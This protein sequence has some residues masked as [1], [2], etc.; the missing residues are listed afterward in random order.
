MSEEIVWDGRT[1]PYIPP[2]ELRIAPGLTLHD[3]AD[4]TIDPVT[5]EVLRHALWNVNT[6]H[7]NTIMKISGSPICAYGHDFNPWHVLQQ[8]P[9]TCPYKR[10]IISQQYS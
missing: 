1:Y 9:N 6:E 7:G 5:H 2:A 8:R 10:M 3:E 4:A